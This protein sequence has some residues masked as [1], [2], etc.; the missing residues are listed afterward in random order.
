MVNCP[1]RIRTSNF[2][3]QSVVPYHLATGQNIWRGFLFSVIHL[4][5]TLFGSYLIASTPYKFYD[6]KNDYVL[7]SV[8]KLSSSL[9]MSLS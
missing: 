1:E 7:S 3:S 5:S 9:F 2:Y 6:I 8:T 4:M